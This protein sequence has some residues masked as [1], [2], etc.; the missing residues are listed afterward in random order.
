M[1]WRRWRWRP[2]WRRRRRRRWRRRRRRPRRRRAYRRRRPRRVRR[3]RGR[4]RRA[5]RRWG[6]RRR[7]RRH[8]KKLLL[9]QWQPPIVKKCLIIGYDPLIICGINRTAFN[10]STHSEDFTFNNESFGGGLCTTQ[11]TLR[12]LFQ[13][14]L[15]QHNFWTASNED[16]DLARYLGGILIMFRHPTVD[17]LVRV[18]TSPP[19]NDTDMTALTLH[20]GMMMLSKKVIKVPSLKTR[21]SRKHYVKIRFGAPKL[22]EDKWYPQNEL[23]DVT[24]VSIQAT[25]ADFQYPFGS[26][27]TNSVCCNFQVLNSN[28]DKA[29]SILN[30]NQVTQE[31][32]TKR[33]SC[34]TF[35]LKQYSYYNTKQTLAQLKFDFF[36][37]Q[38]PKM[39][40]E[41]NA[42]TSKPPE[43]LTKENVNNTYPHWD[44]LY[45]GLAYGFT[46]TT[47][48]ENTNQAKD[49]QSQMIEA[50]KFYTK[51]GKE[52]IKGFT[53]IQHN[54]IANT[55]I[56]DYYTGM[57]CSIF[58]SSGRSNPEVKGSYTDISYNPLTDKGVG[59]MIWIDWLSKPDSIYD[60]SK[61]KCLLRDFPLWCM[62]Y[63]YADYCRKVTGDSAILLDCR[64][65]IR[66]PYTYPQLIKHNNENW[67]FVP[68]SENFGLGRM[69]G[70]NANPS[71]R[72]RLHWYPMLLHQMEVLECLAQTGPFA[73]HGDERKTVLTAKYKF[74]WKWGGNPVFQ[75]VLRDPCTGGAVAPHTSRHPRAIQVFDPKYQAPEYLFHKWDFRRGLFSTKGI[76]R[77]S[78]QPTHDEFLTGRSKRPKKDTG[79]PL[80]QEEQKED[81]R[82]TLPQLRPWLPS[83]Q[84]TQSQSEEEQQTSSTTLQEQL[85]QQLKQQ[86]LMGIQLRDVCLQ[87]A[88][89]QAGHSLHPVFQCHV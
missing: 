70:G 22:F 39:P 82:F 67:G 7:R 75:Q 80:Q 53:P 27:L 55:N 87:L 34:Y 85:Q 54:D 50:N 72:M 19:F 47:D 88:R 16:L 2:W 9:T 25:A 46:P 3:R 15:A 31:L 38:N 35:L 29:L 26:P 20:P 73:Y 64:V 66:C 36:P 1:A 14:K 63:G 18:R 77:V 84:E 57:Y 71:T 41:N 61:S 59:N 4:W 30:T 12:I 83:S 33:Q 68:Y 17:F 11:Y 78:E 62:V 42:H 5:Y 21:P 74:R 32:H 48:A 37:K 79:A 28:Y 56:F 10:Y 81:S 23:C 44:T 58:L 24:L 52:L 13:E 89:V 86:R 8:K 51:A 69:P 43:S 6:R 60:P 45:G 76:K 65:V 40:K 49:L